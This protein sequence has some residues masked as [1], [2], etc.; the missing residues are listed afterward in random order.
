MS[1]ATP[2]DQ[3]S[4]GGQ[5]RDIVQDVLNDLD[6][7]IGGDQEVDYDE[8]DYQHQDRYRQ[9]QHDESQISQYQ[10]ETPMGGH[11][12]PTGQQVEHFQGPGW[13]ELI[14]EHAKSP[15]LFILLFMVLNLEVFQKI[16]TRYL[17]DGGMTGMYS[18]GIRA[19]LGAILFYILRVFVM[20]MV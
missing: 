10:D 20:P 6:D 7:E 3:L 12:Q 5:E 11:V 16:V 8:M 19:V 14:W 15:L 17:P 2:I 1:K 4:G 18:L 13:G 9:Y